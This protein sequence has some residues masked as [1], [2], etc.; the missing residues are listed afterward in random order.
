MDHKQ[1]NTYSRKYKLN[2]NSFSLINSE[3]KAYCLGFFYADGTVRNT[4]NA[5]SVILHLAEKDREILDLFALSLE[6]DSPIKIDKRGYALIAVNSRKLVEDFIKLGA[7]PRKTFKIRF[8]FEKIPPELYKHFIR[9]YIDG[10][11]SFTFDK[12]RECSGAISLVANYKFCE[13]V[14]GILIK[15]CGL[16]EVKIR[17]IPSKVDPTNKVGK[18]TYGGGR[19]FYKLYHY[20]YS[21]ANFFLKRKKDKAEKI[22]QKINKHREKPKH[23]KVNR[24]FLFDPNLKEVE[25]K[26][27]ES[28]FK[29]IGL[30]KISAYA[31]AT[32]KKKSVKGWTLSR[33][34]K[35]IHPTAN[36]P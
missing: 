13:D 33:V 10:D 26:I 30:S 5:Y 22:L 31:L 2:E 1:Y 15:E 35:I 6:T 24:I 17:E 20:L 27:Q 12:K 34:E 7:E 19:S 29:V 36:N 25:V 32:G 16:N 11:G 4:S 28:F 3:L 8:P 18:L 9:G 21:D 23:N 14:M